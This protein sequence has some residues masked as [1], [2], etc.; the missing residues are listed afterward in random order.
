MGCAMS[1]ATIPAKQGASNTDWKT[2]WQAAL[3]DSPAQRA[4]GRIFPLQAGGGPGKA[5]TVDVSAQARQNRRA[6]I[7]ATPDCRNRQRRGKTQVL[8]TVSYT[9][10]TLPT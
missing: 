2:N 9:H 5:E 3:E 4:R 10:L 6:E 8:G 7:A 1:C